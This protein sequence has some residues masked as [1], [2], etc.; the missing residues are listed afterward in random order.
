VPQNSGFDGNAGWGPDQNTLDNNFYTTLLR[1]G[2]VAAF[3]PELQNNAAPFTNK[4]LWR[5]NGRPGFMLN[6]DLAL[7]VDTSGHLDSTNGAVAC[8]LPSQPNAVNPVCP[9]SPLLATANRYAAN[10]AAWVADFRD[11]FTKMVNSGC[12]APTVCTAV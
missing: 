1:N 8:S 4:F 2:R 11:A 9:N 10:N 3:V 12:N 6:A 5:E 7:A